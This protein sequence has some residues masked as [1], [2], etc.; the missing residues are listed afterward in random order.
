ME[1]ILKEQLLILPFY[2][3]AKFEVDSNSFALNLTFGEKIQAAE[4]AEPA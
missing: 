1:L 2:L 3:C 4:T